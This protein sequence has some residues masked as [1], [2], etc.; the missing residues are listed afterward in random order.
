[1][2]KNYTL[3]NFLLL[4]GFLV[5][6]S[7]R[8]FAGYNFTCSVT[9]APFCACDVF[10]VT[11]DGTGLTF[12]AGNVF[13]VQLSDA[14]G[15]FASPIVIGT[16]TSTA[17]TGTVASTIPCNIL[18]GT[19][20]RIRVVSSNNPYTSA[21]N[22]VDLTI[23]DTVTPSA[24]LTVSPNDT[25]CDPG[26]V[27]FSV[28]VNNG[29]PSPSFQWYIG[30][31]PVGANSSTFTTMPNNGDS[32]YC[33]IASN[34]TC[35][36][37]QQVYSDTAIMVIGSTALA[38]SV[39]NTE[40]NT[41]NI[42][43]A[44]DVHYPADCDLMASLTP[45]GASPLNGNTTVAVTIDNGVSTFNGQPYLQRHFDLEPANNAAIATADIKLYAYQS[46]FDAYN[47]AA[48]TAGLPLLPTG[49]VDNGNVRITQFHGVGTAPANYPGPEVLITPTV[50][51]DATHSWWVMSFSVTGFS[52]FYIHT[53]LGPDPLSIKFNSIRAQNEGSV[54]K[55]D[56]SSESEEIGD[57]YTLQRSNDGRNFSN[58][59]TVPA[60][61]KASA[62]SYIDEQPYNGINYYRISMHDVA[63]NSS[64]TKVVSAMVLNGNGFDVTLSPNPARNNI[65]VNLYGVNSGSISITDMT[66]R[67]LLQ[68]QATGTGTSLD[69]SELPQGIYMFRYSSDAGNRNIRFEKL[70]E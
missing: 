5:F 47:L 10:N 13:T 4:S 42:T 51:W 68:Q 12:V 59:A 34:A 46:E 55:I 65:T 11:Y 20:Y 70:K 30:S 22:G 52:G 2:L 53:A 36:T 16:L 19:A 27:V 63:G 28:N 54:N 8:T 66:G 33:L 62:Y 40:T 18:A 29:G 50:T 21:T 15:S 60:K 25:L 61:G 3:R 57:T 69:I 49:A 14:T 6:I 67:T 32:I 48:A 31:V 37:P 56:W 44:T 45:S 9:G 64:Y 23:N 41:A 17:V 43:A 1:M 39:G 7:F 58:M 35:A 38:G 26:L 24:T